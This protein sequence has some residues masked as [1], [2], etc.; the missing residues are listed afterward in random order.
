MVG[1]RW[2]LD[3][4]ASLDFSRPNWAADLRQEAV[5]QGNMRMNELDYFLFPRGV[6]QGIPP[7]IIGRVYWDYWMVWKARSLGLPVVEASPRVVVIHQN[8]ETRYVQE[9]RAGE[10]VF[11]DPGAKWN[12]ELAHCGKDFGDYYDCTHQLIRNGML[13]PTFWRK[14]RN[15]LKYSLWKTFVHDTY[16]LRKRLGLSRGTLKQTP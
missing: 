15:K 8:H 16:N 3:I 14:E 4:T 13:V 9:T 6:Y 7:L 12:Y 11:F 2:D 1:R 5:G 10:G